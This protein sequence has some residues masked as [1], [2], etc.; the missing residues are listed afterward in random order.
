MKKTQN[1]A[2]VGAFVIIAFIFLSLIVFFVSGVYL[3]RSGYSVNVLYDYVSILDKG[4]PVRMAGVRIGEVSKVDLLYDEKTKHTRVKVKLFIEDKVEIR[5]HYQFVIQGTH[6][7]SEPHIEI[8]PVSGDGA[9]ITDGQVIEGFDPIAVEDI[10]ERAHNIAKHLE[11][12]I[13]GLD[14]AI[15]DKDTAT[16]IK[17][18]VVNLADLTESMNKALSGSEGDVK[19]TLV[20]IKTS[21]DSIQRILDKIEKGE[22]T[23]GGLIVKDEIYKDLRDLVK[24]VKLHPW[25]LLKK[26][27]GKKRFFFF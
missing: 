27:G 5:D 17:K 19:T 22:G 21:T 6:I 2:V 11:N 10:I 9:I 1:E 14:N 3:F 23:A 15:Q 8:K 13:A 25:K 16:A 26:D 18:I 7:L 12:I 20:N 4:A 24:D